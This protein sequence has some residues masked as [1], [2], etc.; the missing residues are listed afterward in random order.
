MAIREREYPI[1]SNQ[2]GAPI[3]AGPMQ[4]VRPRVEKTSLRIR[5]R[6]VPRQHEPHHAALNSQWTSLAR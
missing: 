2:S 1:A 5:E 6:Y 3:W 4:F